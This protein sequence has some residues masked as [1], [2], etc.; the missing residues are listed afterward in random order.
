MITNKDY[1]F[2][3]EEEKKEQIDFQKIIKDR[4]EPLKDISSFYQEARKQEE[5]KQKELEEEMN[6]NLPPVPPTPEQQTEKLIA[7]V[8][9]LAKKI[10]ALGGNK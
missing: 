6:K 4:E 1:V 7:A 5:Q 9:S 2:F 10:E 8:E 3:N